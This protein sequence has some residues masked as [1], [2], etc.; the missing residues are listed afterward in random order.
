M[1]TSKLKFTLTGTT[2]ATVSSYHANTQTRKRM[3]IDSAS[4][5]KRKSS[6]ALNINQI[7]GSC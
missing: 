2:R 6:L 1:I 4:F 3:C 5:A 7:Y